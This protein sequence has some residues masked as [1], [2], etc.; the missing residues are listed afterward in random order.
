M[1]VCYCLIGKT[2]EWYIK[3][4]ILPLYPDLSETNPI[5]LICDGHSSHFTIDV[6]N[7]MI[8][9]HIHLI[10]RPPH[11]SQVSQGNLHD[12]HSLYY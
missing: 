11:T 3:K 1:Y 2:M 12:I 8:A 7:L 10:L 6:L 9:N 4:N 5:V